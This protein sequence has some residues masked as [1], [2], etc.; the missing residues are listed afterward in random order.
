VFKVT[1]FKIK[2]IDI[3]T[4]RR[5]AL[6]NINDADKLGI[7]LHD[8]IKIKHGEKAIIAE[9]DITKTVIQTG[10]IGVFQDLVPELGV[11]DGEKVTI[12]T[13]PIP[14]SVGYIHKKMRG[15]RLNKEE[16]SCIIKDIASK[17]LNDLEIAAFVIAQSYHGMTMDEIKALAEAMFETGER[18]DFE[19]PVYDK[20]SIG[21]IP[22]NK[23]SL[24]I[25]PIVAAAGLLI[26]KTSSKAITSASGTADTMSV[27]APVEFTADELKKIALKAG[28]AI[29]WGGGLNL[30]PADDLIINVEHPLQIDPESQMLASILAKKM[31]VGAN[32]LVIDIPVGRFAKVE[33]PEEARRL[34]SRFVELGERLGIRIRCGITYGGQPVG[35]AVGPALEAREA[36]ET[37]CSGGPTSLI[38]KSTAIAGMLLELSGKVVKGHGQEYAKEILQSGKALK[39]MREIIGV[40]GGDPKI[41]PEDI[42]IGQYKVE[43]KSEWDGYV[44]SVSN[45]AIRVIA[46]AAGAPMDKGAGVILSGKVGYKVKKGQNIL[47][48]YAERESKLDEAVSIAAKMRPVTIEGMLLHELPEY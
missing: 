23:V 17:Y 41:K 32:Y 22:G 5:F 40:Q 47:E 33:T 34:S 10:E 12:S 2:I 19:K 39:K 16:I 28:G 46:R 18:I 37:L 29:V 36:L 48:I 6:L 15:E 30:A 9:V 27:L 44:T 35:H 21:G 8:R 42:P 25:V 3:S 31:A 1:T 26:P 7:R 45:E 43:I 20:H 14:S 38:E 4:G 13:M 11:K 24:L